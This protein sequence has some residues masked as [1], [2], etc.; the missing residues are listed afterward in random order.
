MPRAYDF[1]VIVGP[2]ENL[3][4]PVT[5]PARGFIRQHFDNWPK[6][7]GQAIALN[8]EQLNNLVAWVSTVGLR[9]EVL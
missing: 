6:G 7:I 5:D 8:N 9:I 3:I 1:V 2:V 4:R